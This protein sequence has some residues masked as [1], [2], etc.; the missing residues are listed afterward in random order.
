MFIE[1][2]QDT[3]CPWCRIGK[4]NLDQALARWDGERVSVRFKAFL[5]DPSLPPEGTD[6]RPLMAGKMAGP[7]RV[8]QI[9]GRVTEAG[10]VAGV[11]FDFS[12]V[13]LMPNSFLSHQLIMLAPPQ[14][15]SKTFDAITKAYFEENVN[16]GDVDELVKI[17]ERTGITDID[18]R[19]LLTEGAAAGR[20]LEDLESAREL[21]IQGVPFI[22]INGRHALYGAQPVEALL[23]ALTEAAANIEEE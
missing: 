20:V 21:G 22:L 23:R 12:N 11:H 15:A 8:D 3:V 2:Y 17:A 10:L 7:A 18:V 4:A 14:L 6:F 9:F 13:T 5:L 16:I 19:Q 1:F